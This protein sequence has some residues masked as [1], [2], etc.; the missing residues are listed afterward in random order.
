[1]V[2]EEREQWFSISGD[3]NW[4][5]SV[6]RNFAEVLLILLIDMKREAQWNIKYL[7]L[8]HSRYMRSTKSKQVRVER[9]KKY[10]SEEEIL[11]YM[12]NNDLL[13]F[14]FEIAYEC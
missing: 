10:S 11:A 4:D 13:L 14:F 2:V 7:Q 1:M 9:I 8:D 12:N 5:L 3:E 6:L